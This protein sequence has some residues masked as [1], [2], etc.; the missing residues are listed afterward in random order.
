MFPRWTW[1][2]GDTDHHVGLSGF[3]YRFNVMETVCF[4]QR[5]Q[6][7]VWSAPHTMPHTRLFW[8]AC[9]KFLGQDLLP[10]FIRCE[11]DGPRR[12]HG[13][14][15]RRQYCLTGVSSIRT[16]LAHDTSTRMQAYQR[17]ML[18]LALHS[19]S[20]FCVLALNSTRVAKIYSRIQF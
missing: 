19:P 16:Q 20:F 4:F 3:P 9:Q 1:P 18:Y 10:A 13:E 14:D 15:N 6:G 7:V 17:Q 2:Y 5:M 11:P 12:D 8:C